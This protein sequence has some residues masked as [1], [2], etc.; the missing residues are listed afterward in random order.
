MFKLISTGLRYCIRH[1]GVVDVDQEV[2][3]FKRETDGPCVL[4]QLVYRRR[5]RA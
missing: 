5:R 4:R 2:C 3:D 1:Q